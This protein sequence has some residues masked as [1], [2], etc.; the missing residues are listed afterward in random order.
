MIGW[1]Y[2]CYLGIIINNALFVKNYLSLDDK[3]YYHLFIMSETF[4]NIIFGHPLAFLFPFDLVYSL[5][6]KS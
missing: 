4:S 3:L 6:L 1:I 2:G 5:V